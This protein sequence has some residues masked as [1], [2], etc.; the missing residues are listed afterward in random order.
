[1]TAQSS[2]NA[3]ATMGNPTPLLAV[4]DLQIKYGSITALRGLSIHVGG[5]E[6]VAVVGPNGAGKSSLLCAIAGVV[7]SAKGAITFLGKP[8]IGLSPEDILRRGIAMVPEGRHIFGSMT[9]DENLRLGATVRTDR[10]AIAKDIEELLETFPILRER[11]KQPAGRLSGGEQQQLAIARALLCKPRL[12]ML[13]EPSLGLAPIV[14]D[15]VY[16]ILTMLRQRGMT[17]LLIEQNATRALNTA[18]RTYVLSAGSLRLSGTKTEL[19]NNRDFDAAYFG[20]AEA[21]T[22]VLP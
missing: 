22:R 10:G 7:P 18:D 19:L 2:G 14:I 15:Q 11:R 6:I 20:V 16:Q 21:E 8:L 3:T 13:D 12:L 5:G 9:V 17:I 1:M 4:S